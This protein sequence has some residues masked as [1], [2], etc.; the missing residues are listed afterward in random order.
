MHEYS[1]AKEISEIVIK[2]ANNNKII[3]IELKI[4]SLSGVF[5]ESVI[6][7]LE[8]IFNEKG[9]MPIKIKIEA[10]NALFKCNCGKEYQ[11][12][13]LLLSCPECGKFERDIIA[14]NECIIKN[15][16]IED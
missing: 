14:G 3:A 13:N 15:I 11:A 6:F 8:L 10:E 1:I 2:N 12:D 4:G 5:S 16:I 7:Y 9:L